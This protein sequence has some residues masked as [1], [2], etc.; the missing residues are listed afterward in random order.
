MKSYLRFLSRNKLYTV[1]EV[2]G[3]SLA[4]AFVIP[5]INVVADKY[6]NMNLPVERQVDNDGQT[7]TQGIQRPNGWPTRSKW[8]DRWLHSDMK[9]VSY[10]YNFKFY[11]KVV[12]KG[13]LQ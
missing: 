13:E 10:F 1:I 9:D 5:M 2:V 11:E 4:L 12:E 6:V 7:I 3:L 8:N